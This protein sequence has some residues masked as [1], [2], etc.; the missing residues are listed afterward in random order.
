MIVDFL[1]PLVGNLLLWLWLAAAVAAWLLTA[2]SPRRRLVAL[3]LLAAGWLLSTRPV[4][5]LAL[6]RLECRYAQPSVAALRAAGVRQVLVL[7]GGGYP[8][9]G[10]LLASDFP[11]ATTFRYLAGVELCSRL[12]PDCRLVFSGSAGRG[13]RDLATAVS[14]QELTRLLQPQRE[15]AAEA[16]SDT[17]AEHPGNVR[18]LLGGEPFALV[19]SAYHLP[20]AMTL[21]HRAGLD[22]VP[23]PVDFLAQGRY[24]WNDWLPS[25]ESLWKLDVAF[26]ETLA[27]AYYLLR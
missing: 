15:V 12:G 4:A 11:Q 10:E 20:R 24:R 27:R 5:E 13:A 1:K 25:A 21:F 9:Q 6:R 22:P 16:D 3:A 18:P 23:Y 8:Q 7:T 19:T 17:T 26:T 2:G 14:M